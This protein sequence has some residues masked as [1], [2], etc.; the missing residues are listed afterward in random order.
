MQYFYYADSFRSV[1][2]CV[3]TETQVLSNMDMAR[4][5]S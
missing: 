5:Y 1:C 3:F 4:I 2:V